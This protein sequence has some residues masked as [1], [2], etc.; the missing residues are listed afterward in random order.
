M[1][2]Q[3]LMKQAQQMQAKMQKIDKELNETS[4]EGTAGGGAVKVTV[5]GTMEVTAI[6]I[7]QDMMD[8]A[9][10]VA[11]SVMVAVNKALADAKKDRESK[12]GR[13]RQNYACARR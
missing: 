4:Y 2:I 1:N 7:D 3:A 9:E 5:M 6:E 12:M 11:E 13:L 8:D 10:V